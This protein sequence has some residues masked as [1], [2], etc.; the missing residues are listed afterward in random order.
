MKQSSHSVKWGT[1][2]R[3]AV[4]SLSWL[5]AIAM[6]ARAVEWPKQITIVVPFPPGAS[7]D[8]FARIIA[9]KL[10]PKLGATIIVD[11][12]PGAA[13]SIGATHVARSAPNGAT[14]MLISSTFTGNSAIQPKLPF[15]P[16]A[17]FVPVA[18]LAQGPMILA[19]GKDAPFSS[20]AELIAAARSEK[21]KLNFGTA[22]VGSINHMASELLNAAAKVEMTHVPYRGI[23]NAVT[24]LMS[25][26]I[27]MV[28]ASFPSIAGLM[29]SGKVR[30][31]A[32]TSAAPS[33]FAPDLPAVAATLPGY[34]VDLWWGVFAPAGLPEAMVDQLNQL[35]RAIIMEPDMRERFAQEGAMATPVSSA[36]FA[37]IVRADLDKW[38]KIARERNIVGN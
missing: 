20:V 37:A 14:L 4:L 7:N 36:E 8:T 26:Q 25:G 29:T 23:S 3:V 31:L 6:P 12:K 38:R 5:L 21:G 18:Q 34:D 15:D 11:N 17:S 35:I 10:G 19:V 13:G 16:V 9:Q 28:I 1:S 32:V 2:V 33:S 30:G 27:Q 22:G 24:D